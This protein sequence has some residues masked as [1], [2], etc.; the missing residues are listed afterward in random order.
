MGIGLKI[1]GKGIKAKIGNCGINS[2]PLSH[3]LYIVIPS[4]DLEEKFSLYTY[5]SINTYKLWSIPTCGA[6]RNTVYRFLVS[7]DQFIG[8]Y[9]RYVHLDTSKW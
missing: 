4:M 3:L 5:L 1:K 2:L 6:K 9:V 8:G 7:C